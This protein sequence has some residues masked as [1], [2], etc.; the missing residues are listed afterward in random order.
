MSHPRQRAVLDAGRV[1]SHRWIGHD[2]SMGISLKLWRSN[3]DKCLCAFCGRQR[4]FYGK[5]HVGILDVFAAIAIGVLVFMPIS[6][7]FDPR[8]LALGSI[9]IGFAEVFVVVRHRMSLRC[10]RCGFD[11]IIYRRSQDEAARLVRE[12][13]LRRNSDPKFLLAEPVRP[14][15]Y[16]K[17]SRTQSKSQLKSPQSSKSIAKSAGKLPVKAPAKPSRPAE[18]R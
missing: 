12:H 4:R 8:G 13:L 7:G 11:P 5:S 3:R 17:S 1:C 9:L 6:D 2:E 16:Q 15:M 10:G 18:T 14:V